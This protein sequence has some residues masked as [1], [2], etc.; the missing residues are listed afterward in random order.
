MNPQG[1]LFVGIGLFSLCGAI[2]DW[3]WFI[4]SRK[5][6]LFVAIFGRGGARVFY[7]VLGTAIA[8]YG[9]LSSMGIIPN[10]T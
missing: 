5:A 4:N 10:A 1:L 3:D 6:R 2:C 8:T 7:A 9:A